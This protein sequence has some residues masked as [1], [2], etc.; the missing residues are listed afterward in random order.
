LSLFRPSPINPTTN[1]VIDPTIDN[2]FVVKIRGNLSCIAY[3]LLILGIDNSPVYTGTKTTLVTPLYNNENLSISIAANTSNCVVGNAY[4]YKVLVYYTE[5]LYVTSDE[6]LFWAYTFPTLSINM[7]DTNPYNLQYFKFTLNYTQAEN[8]GIKEF[9]YNFYD[10]SMTLLD[11]YKMVG[12][13]KTDYYKDGFKSGETYY[14][15]ATVTNQMDVSLD[16]EL[17]SFTVQYNEAKFVLTPIVTANESDNSI[18]VSWSASQVIG[19]PSDESKIKYIQDFMYIGDVGLQIND[20]EH[21]DY[22]IDVPEEF[23]YYH[24]FGVENSHTGDLVTINTVEGN[25]YVLSFDGTNFNYHKNTVTLLSTQDATN[26]GLNYWI[27]AMQPTRAVFIFV[28]G[29]ELYP[30]DT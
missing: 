2:V 1:G 11:T 15:Q 14:I 20:D 7:P 22:D 29:E 4:K 3:Q 8:V 27:V 16:S 25:K 24:I 23:T 6:I 19:V 5:S 12:T 21:V 10:N 30:S 18:T 28:D 26:D 9:E 13:S 17:E